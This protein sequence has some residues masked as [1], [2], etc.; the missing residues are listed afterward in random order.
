MKTIGLLLLLVGLAT[1]GCATRPAPI[2]LTQ[3]DIIS[4]AKADT[5]DEEII[6]RIDTSHTVFRLGAADVVRLRNEGVSE[7]VVNYMLETYPRYVAAEQLRQDSYEND[8]RYRYGYWYGYPRR[9]WW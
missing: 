3:A 2:P 9:W 6:R 7:R 1:A 4:M 5:T 8:Y